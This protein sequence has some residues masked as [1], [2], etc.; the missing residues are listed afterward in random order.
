MPLQIASHQQ[1]RQKLL[2]LRAIGCGEVGRLL[3]LLLFG[4]LF[5]LVQAWLRR[6]DE[7]WS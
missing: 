6:I 4:T 7:A 2:G 1:T 3:M 5:A